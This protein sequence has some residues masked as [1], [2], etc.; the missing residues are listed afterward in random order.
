MSRRIDR[1][2]IL[3]IILAF[4][5]ST[6]LFI[7][8]FFITNMISFFNY[9]SISEENNL[10]EQAV[11]DLDNQLIYFSCE[12]SVL[13]DVSEKLD[14]VGGFLGILEQRFGKD[15]SRVLEQKKIYT[16][17]EYKHFQF[18]SKFSEICDKNFSTILFFYSNNDEEDDQSETTAYIITSFKKKSSKW[19]M[20][21]SFDYNLDSKLIDYM[22]EEYNIT[23]APAVI[24]NGEKAFYL[25]NIEQLEERIEDEQAD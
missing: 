12:D 25:S 10:I 21:Y 13:F 19:V 7:D 18:I 17:L 20:V 11:K 5:I 24:V 6:I 9:K 14:N 1:P 2:M 22:K 16:V 8:L 23:F 15:D 4:I 3:R